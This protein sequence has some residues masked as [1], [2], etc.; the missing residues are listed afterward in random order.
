MHSNLSLCDELHSGTPETQSINSEEKTSV[1]TPVVKTSPAIPAYEIKEE[2][3]NGPDQ[4]IP[5]DAIKAWN[6]D[7]ATSLRMGDAKISARKPISVPS[8]LQN[9]ATQYPDHRALSVKRNG[10]W[11]NFTYSQYRQDVLTMSKAF[12]KL[13]LDRFHGVCI[14]G[15]NSPEWFISDLAAIHAG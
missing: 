14:L 1:I 3:L 8:L 4:I 15:F 9:V 10:V 11:Q 5:S 7:G 6:P 2:Y 13:G 12:I